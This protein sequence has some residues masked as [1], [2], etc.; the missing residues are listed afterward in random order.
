MYPPALLTPAPNHLLVPKLH[1]GRELATMTQDMKAR[2]EVYYGDETC[3]EKLI[4]LLK[5]IGLPN[6]LLTVKE[7][8]EFGYV[9]DT[10]FVWLRHKKKRDYH[11]FEKVVISYDTE[12]TAYFEHKKIKNL[13]GVKAKDFLIWITL[14]EICVKD[15]SCAAAACITFKTPAGLSKSFPLSVFKLEAI[16]SQRETN[17]VDEGK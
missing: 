2:G 6:G 15:K 10:G 8:E 17:E 4:F 14:S 9:K 3:R 11:K 13:T 5:E 7:I 12:V 16:V 1:K